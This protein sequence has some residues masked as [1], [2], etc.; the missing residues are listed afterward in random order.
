MLDS[1]LLTHTTHSARE[2]SRNVNYTKLLIYEKFLEQKKCTCT[3]SKRKRSRRS[4]LLFHN[5][6]Q[7]AA[8]GSFNKFAMRENSWD[9]N[10]YSRGL[11]SALWEKLT[12]SK[13]GEPRCAAASAAAGPPVDILADSHALNFVR[14]S[15]AHETAATSLTPKQ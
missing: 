9:R 12:I 1:L 7:R 14:P 6:V 2:R 15:R 4:K 5:D 3:A 11:K 13:R 8:R 10:F